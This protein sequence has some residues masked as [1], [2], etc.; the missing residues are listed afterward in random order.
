[1]RL[2]E[3]DEE[4]T[5]RDL[6]Q[7]VQLQ[8][9][10]EARYLHHSPNGGARHKKTAA[11][12]KAMGTRRGFPDLALFVPRGGYSGL[13]IELKT[14]KGRMS[15][16]QREWLRHFDKIGWRAICCRGFDEARAE[17][18]GYLRG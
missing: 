10:R 16:D 3:S 14:S 6:V 1:M 9:P 15:P 8:W 7:F 2:F 17:L 12:L 5:Q 18:E 4:T 13:V 11:L